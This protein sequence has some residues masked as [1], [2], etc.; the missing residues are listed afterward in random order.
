[1]TPGGRGLGAE[2]VQ[3]ALLRPG[4]GHARQAQ[5]PRTDLSI[6]VNTFITCP[7][8]P[9]WRQDPLMAPRSS[10]CHGRWQNVSSTRASAPPDPPAAARCCRSPWTPACSPPPQPPA[11]RPTGRRPGHGR[12]GRARTTGLWA[13]C[14]CGVGLPTLPPVW[15]QFDLRVRLEISGTFPGSMPGKSQ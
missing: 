9:R 7:P 6:L 8:M 15:K 2:P 13:G 5:G 14:R 11:R 4:R 3:P 12:P 1:M 10:R